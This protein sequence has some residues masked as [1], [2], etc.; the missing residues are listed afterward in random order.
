MKFNANVSN[1]SDVTERTRECGRN[2]YFQC[3]KSNNSKSIEFSSELRFLRSERCL[4]V[5]NICVKFHLNILNDFEV[6]ERTRVCG[7]NYHFPMFK[8]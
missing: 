4:M 8:R 3:S 6:T 2:G 5:F 1:Y 7:K